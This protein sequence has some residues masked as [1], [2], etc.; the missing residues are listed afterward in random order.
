M[1]METHLMFFMTI[2]VPYQ[3]LEKL[4]LM[5]VKDFLLVLL[6]KQIHTQQP[7][8]RKPGIYLRLREQFM[9]NIKTINGTPMLIFSLLAAVWMFNIMGHSHLQ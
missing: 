7:F 3:F 2:L 8:N 5:L 9:G 4:R 6:S 1:N